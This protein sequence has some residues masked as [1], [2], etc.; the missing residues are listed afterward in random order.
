MGT[1]FQLG[2]EARYAP[3]SNASS[4]IFFRCNEPSPAVVKQLQGAAIVEVK[5]GWGHSVALVSEKTENKE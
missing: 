3:N 5:A 2:N 4:H 1:D